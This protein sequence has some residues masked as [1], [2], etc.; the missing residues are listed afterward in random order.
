MRF[1]LAAPLANGLFLDLGR[2][3]EGTGRSSSSSESESRRRGCKRISAFAFAAA[4]MFRLVPGA[5]APLFRRGDRDKEAIEIGDGSAISI[6]MGVPCTLN[7]V[8]ARENGVL[9]DFLN[10]LLGS[11][12]MV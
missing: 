3:G 10:G 6:S 5:L 9:V 7:M 1:G 4:K 8:C 11:G 12:D 2:V